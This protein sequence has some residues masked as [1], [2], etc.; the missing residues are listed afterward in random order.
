MEATIIGLGLIAIAGVGFV[1]KI[2]QPR[3]NDPLRSALKIFEI[4]DKE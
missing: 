4:S 1:T 3:L 2:V